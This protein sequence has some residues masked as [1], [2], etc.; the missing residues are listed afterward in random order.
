MRNVRFLLLVGLCLFVHNLAAGEEA[1]SLQD[2]EGK[3]DISPWPEG[4]K[5]VLSTE[6]ASDGKTSLKLHLGTS[7]AFWQ[8]KVKDWRP[9]QILRFVINNPNDKSVTVGLEIRDKIQ[10]YRDNYHYSVT[11]SP[12]I[13]SIDVD[14]ATIWRGEINKQFANSKEPFHKED[15]QRLAFFTKELDQSKFIYIDQVELVKVEKVMAKGAFA[16]DF[17]GKGGHFQTGWIPVTESTYYKKDLGYGVQGNCRVWG[18][19]PLPTKVLGDGLSFGSFQ[20]DLAG[21][22]YIGWF[23]MERS[24]FWS[25]EASSYQQF[26]LMLNGTSVSTHKQKA[27]DS[28]FHFQD[29]EITSQ[30]EVVHNLVFERARETNFKFKATNGA[31]RFKIRTQGAAGTPARLAGLVLAPDTKEGQAYL[32]RIKKEQYEQ[33]AK[34]NKLVDKSTKL[35]SKTNAKEPILAVPSIA[36]YKLQPGD[37]PKATESQEIPEMITVNGNDLYVSSQIG[38]YVANGMYDVAAE[39]TPFSSGPH[40]IP[41]SNVQIQFGRYMP[42]RN[43]DGTT[44]WIVN[45]HYYPS[46]RSTVGDNLARSILVS[47]DAKKGLAPGLYQARLSLRFTGKSTKSILKTIDLKLRVLQGKLDTIPVFTGLW[48]SKVSVP[49]QLV[50]EES[51]WMLYETMVQYL[52]KAH[53]TACVGGPDFNVTWDGDAPTIQGGDGL[54][55]I[56]IAQKYAVADAIIDYGGYHLN[57]AD[58]QAKLNNLYKVFTT[59]QK[60]HNL[61]VFYKYLYDEPSSYQDFKDFRVAIKKVKAHNAAGFNTYG[62]SSLS[63]EDGPITGVPKDLFSLS[64]ATAVNLHSP[65]GMTRLKDL[66][67]IP[68]IYNNG[69]DRYGQGVHLYRAVSLGARSKVDWIATI[70]QG[71]QY[72]MLD[73]REPDHSVFYFHD[74][75]GVLFSPSYLG[76]T[77]GAFDAMVLFTLS[78]K[79]NDPKIK[80]FLSKIEAEPYREKLPDAEM[81]NL[82]LEGLKLL[83]YSLN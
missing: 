75:H 30:K 61:P 68:M 3:L 14:V 70:I 82:R 72:D 54:K 78:A 67:T 63:R 56:K 22:D 29:V 60:E 41:S 39:L 24:G 65:G 33:V 18:E 77:E 31:N 42:T 34:V 26:D 36:N 58:T 57:G 25:G 74:K 35:S 23:V 13:H 64:T 80:A 8:L 27:G 81:Q 15:I 38:L 66:G 9:Y 49:K 17:S 43:Y 46:T 5:M 55:A 40:T 11:A 6:W 62:C 50:G 51:Y 21:G 4:R 71:F 59:F 12:G 83:G 73:G 47:I 48:G 7:T 53:K 76:L 44:C 19:L 20:V 10:S 79:A 52:Q 28:Y 16:F 2:M 69:L 1:V 45:H 32:Q 37:W